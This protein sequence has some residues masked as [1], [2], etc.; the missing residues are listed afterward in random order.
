MQ[1]SPLQQQILKHG[2]SALIVG[3]PGS[4]KTALLL[5]HAENLLRGG[6]PKVA[7][8]TFAFRTQEHLKSIAQPSLKELWPRLVAQTMKDLAAAQLAA[9]GHTVNFATNNQ[10]REI[11]RALIPAHAFTGSV[12]DAEHILRSAKSHAKKLPENDRYFPFVQAY[13]ARLDELGLM[14]R[15]DIIR[16]H[17]RGMRDGSLK[18]APVTH[19]LLDNLQDA[20]ELQLIWLQM[21]LNAG[22][23]LTLT[24]D[25]DIT[26]YGLD[27][28]M[29]PAALEQ[30][31]E[32]PDVTR[33]ELPASWR[34]PPGL[35]GA[36]GKIA[37][38]LR[39]RVAKPQD[40]LAVSGGTLRAEVFPNPPAEH[41]FLADLCFQLLSQN[42]KVGILTRTHLAAAQITHALRKH[43]AHIIRND[44][45]LSLSHAF[46]PAGF[47]RPVWDEPT[48]QLVL[49]MLYLMLGQGGT[50]H[51]Q[52]VLLGFG[53]PPQAVA[54][55][56]QLGLSGQNWLAEGCP[57]PTV[58]EA[59]PT[60]L[61]SIRQVRRAFRAAA[62][63][64]AEKG[65]GKTVSPRD[66]FKSLLAELLPH[67]PESEH[68]PALLAADMLL[69]LS[70]KLTEILPR[71]R[72]ETLPD[73]ASPIT[74][75]TVHEARNREF[76]TVILPYAGAQQW[77][78][79]ASALLGADLDHDRRLFYLA[80]SRTKGN[81]I[82]T[83]HTPEPS[84]YLAELQ[85]SLRPKK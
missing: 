27:G 51:L 57:L 67:L 56:Q 8:V 52:V 80:A 82:I 44:A 46:N 81:L 16:R 7:L 14:D 49:A 47:F 12:G 34:T 29:G 22:I 35:S 6:T 72:Q 78:H 19:L 77:P 11:L 30:V 20:T 31:E 79:P 37:R 28:A 25:D 54:A 59:S 43:G 2:G 64:L 70:G 38:Q 84:P 74:V 42:Q 13:Q 45:T 76:D 3:C 60:T 24:A 10:V 18:P 83:R 40:T 4:G 48:P 33:F 39:T 9:A 68:P 62:Q 15:H 36:V 71:V 55:M 32:W 66:V 73:M 50:G 41:V 53:V 61:A 58:P 17:I 69:N 75:A 1:W 65:A 21:H 5:A 63:L 26:V 85:Q 23:H